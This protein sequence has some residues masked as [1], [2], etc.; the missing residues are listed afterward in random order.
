MDK[1]I[2]D[3]GAPWFDWEVIAECTY[4][5]PAQT[6]NYV[7]DCGEPALYKAQWGYTNNELVVSMNVCQKHLDLIEKG[8]EES[9]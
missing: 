9:E 2:E 1:L 8:E 5:V 6:P 7:D 3:L 4:P